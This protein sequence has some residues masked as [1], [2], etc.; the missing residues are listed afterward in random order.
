MLESNV[1]TQRIT[2][3]VITGLD[4]LPNQNILGVLILLTYSLILLGSSANICIIV[5]DQLLHRPMY[6]FICNLAV[7]DIMFTTSASTTLIAL[8]LAGVRNISYHS[9]ISRK[10]SKSTLPVWRKCILR[11]L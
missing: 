6:I 4:H 11:L 1:T 9:C 2:E 7:I 10:T 3:F 5:S 8:L